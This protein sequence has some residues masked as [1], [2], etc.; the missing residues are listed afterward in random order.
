MPTVRRALSADADAIV[1]LLSDVFAPDPF[2]RWTIGGG[3][4]RRRRRYVDLILRRLTLPHGEVW[5]DDAGRGAALWSPPGTWQLPAL[6]QLALLPRVI[7]VV[8]FRRM[9][10]VAQ[11]SEQIEA[12]RPA[13][14]HYYLALL[15][16]ETASRRQGVGRR[17][18]R[19]VLAQ[20]DDSGSL[21][22]LDTSV[23]ANVAFYRGSGFEVSRCIDLED[24]PPVWTMTRRPR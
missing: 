13:E 10:V 11:A 22:V 16:T 5:V 3:G 4:E 12:G 15:G 21:C 23:E 14:P 20:A 17:L 1:A 9:G 24:G 18:L 7:G 2:V 8:G 6:T 19:P